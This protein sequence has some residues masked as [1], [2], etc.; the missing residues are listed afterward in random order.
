MAQQVGPRGGPED[1]FPLAARLQQV[2]IP[3]RTSQSITAAT[4][5]AL[6]DPALRARVKAHIP[7]M[8]PPRAAA[9]GAHEQGRR[10]QESAAV[11]QLPLHGTLSGDEAA[12]PPDEQSSEGEGDS[13]VL[14]LAL[15]AALLVDSGDDATAV[16]VSAVVLSWLWS[17]LCEAVAQR[18]AQ[19][20]APPRRRVAGTRPSVAPAEGASTPRDALVVRQGACIKSDGGQSGECSPPFLD[21]EQ[22]EVMAGAVLFLVLAT[23]MAL[24]APDGED[25]LGAAVR[26][27]GLARGAFRD[28]SAVE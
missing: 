2:G 9:Q 16:A 1:N 5:S 26:V 3:A 24:D 10:E 28:R 21:E 18:S 6:Q 20:Q 11:P 8:S 25:I 27:V 22:C 14:R 17:R 19:R 23:L 15:S 7:R 4:S 12:G 13:S